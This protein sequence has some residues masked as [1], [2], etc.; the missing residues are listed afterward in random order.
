MCKVRV[1]AIMARARGLDFYRMQRGVVL[2]GYNTA[3]IEYMTEVI[4]LGLIVLLFKRVYLSRY[5]Y[6]MQGNRTTMIQK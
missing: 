2:L 6:W 3:S 5:P 4:Y 1:T